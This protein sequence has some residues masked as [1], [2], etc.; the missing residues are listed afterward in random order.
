M[1]EQLHFSLVGLHI[2]GNKEG[3]NSV[4]FSIGPGENKFIELKS[5]GP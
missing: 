1:K 4:S 2:D 3:D 5:I